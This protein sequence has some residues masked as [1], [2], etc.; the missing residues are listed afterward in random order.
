MSY[1]LDLQSYILDNGNL[2]VLRFVSLAR[3][4]R[5]LRGSYFESQF[6]VPVHHAAGKFVKLVFQEYFLYNGLVSVQ[7]DV[8]LL[9]SVHLVHYCEVLVNCVVGII[10]GHTVGRAFFHFRFVVKV[11]NDIV[12]LVLNA[13]SGAGALLFHGLNCLAKC[14]AVSALQRG[15]LFLLVLLIDYSSDAS[16]LGT[17]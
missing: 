13:C 5:A 7:G 1:G 8:V 12:D 10:Y 3:R 2:N 17:Q 9:A 6:L 4:L 11:V 14:K 16:R 15:S